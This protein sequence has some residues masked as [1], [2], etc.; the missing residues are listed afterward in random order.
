MEKEFVE[1]DGV[2]YERL[3]KGFLIDDANHWFYPN[4][5]PMA[6]GTYVND[7]GDLVEYNARFQQLW[8]IDE[9]DDGASC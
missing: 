4:G 6:D 1:V 9:E 8:E 3:P 2:S 7:F 5:E